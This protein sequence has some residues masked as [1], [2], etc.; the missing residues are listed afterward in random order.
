MG[1]RINVFSWTKNTT[2][3]LYYYKEVYSGDSLEEALKISYVEKS[4]GVGC[5]KIEWR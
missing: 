3:D 2:D 5:I 4:N 1:H